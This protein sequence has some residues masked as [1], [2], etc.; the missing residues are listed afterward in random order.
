MNQQQAQLQSVDI[1]NDTNEEIQF[2]DNA[3][4]SRIKSTDICLIERIAQGQFSSVWKSRCH[5]Y[6]EGD[7]APEY[8]IKIF[9]GH[10]KTAWQNEKDIFNVMCA[11]NENILTFFGADISDG[12]Y[13]ALD[14]EL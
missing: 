9:A 8:A 14:F 3:L 4:P 2:V 5:N 10:Q 7:D 1:S 6:L 12:I 13:D 11:S